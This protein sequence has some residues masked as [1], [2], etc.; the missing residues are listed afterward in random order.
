MPPFL[1]TW[2][3]DNIAPLSHP[4]AARHDWVAFVLA[5]PTWVEDDPNNSDRTLLFRHIGEARQ[6]MRVVV[7]K[8]TGAVHN[9]FW[10]EQ[11]VERR[12]RQQRR[13]RRGEDQ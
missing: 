12:R 10:D 1:T 5:R 3:F 4:E 11:Y 9:A 13:Q 8:E 6:Y 7:I 2:Y